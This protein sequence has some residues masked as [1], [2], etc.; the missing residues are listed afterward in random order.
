MKKRLNFSVSE[1]D[2]TSNADFAQTDLELI[3]SK[4]IDIR[5]NGSVAGRRT[6]LAHQ[7]YLWVTL[8]AVI[9]FEINWTTNKLHR[10]INNP[11][12][13]KNEQKWCKELWNCEL[14]SKK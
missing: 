5:N 3:E 14:K 11:Y 4:I 12:E 13:A 9:Q 10:R 8:I 1:M 7:I 6:K 2:I